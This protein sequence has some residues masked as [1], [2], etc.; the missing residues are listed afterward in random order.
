VKRLLL[1]TVAF[2]GLILGGAV[3]SPALAASGDH[4]TTQTD[5]NFV[6]GTNACKNTEA[7]FVYIGTGSV[8]AGGDGTSWAYNTGGSNCV[9][10]TRVRYI[11]N[12]NGKGYWTGWQS[13]SSKGWVTAGFVAGKR[14]WTETQFRRNDGSY[15]T[16]RLFAP[17]PRSGNCDV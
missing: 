17:S 1:T 6:G 7:F 5:T 16:V 15:R 4:T 11:R 10:K 12:S 9:V 14:C 13:S 8:G 3:A 2:V